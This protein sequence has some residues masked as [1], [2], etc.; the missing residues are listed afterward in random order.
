M[1]SAAARSS[2]ESGA[3]Q[4][5]KREP[6]VSVITPAWNAAQYIQP[7]MDSLLKQSY[8]NWEWLI[9][10][11]GSTDNTREIIARQ[12]DS[13]IRLIQNKHTGLPAAGRNVGLANAKG[14]FVAFLD[15]D[16]LWLPEKIEQQIALFEKEPD[17]GLVFSPYAVWNDGETSPHRILPDD[18][19]HLPNPGNYFALLCLKNRIGNSTVVVRRSLL[20]EHGNLDEDPA[21]RGSEDY[22]LWLR[23]SRFTRFAFVPV[24]LIWY[25][26]HA[27]S[28]SSNETRNCRTSMRVIEKILAR[29]PEDGQ[30]PSSRCLKANWQYYLGRAQ[31]LDGL[32]DK[33][34]RALANSLL[35][36]PFN[37][38]AWL[39]LLIGLTFPG[40]VRTLRRRFGI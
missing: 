16:D 4:G 30:R 18:I 21:V 5:S 23:L 15:S 20:L 12:S 8:S 28:V 7:T 10:D 36:W 13:R 33:G 9:V 6:L 19:A 40:S 38:R 3:A 37:S 24:P 26:V 34:R 27:N 14:D 11:D 2:G 17:V 1:T 22:E 39:Y 29:Y 25:R 31:L 32:D 35:L